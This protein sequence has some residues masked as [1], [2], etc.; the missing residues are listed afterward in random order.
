MY[1][2]LFGLSLPPPLTTPEAGSINDNVEDAEVAR[3][4]LE[5]KLAQIISQTN[6][7][8]QEYQAEQIVYKQAR[9]WSMHL[10]NMA[11]VHAFF[12]FQFCF[13]FFIVIGH[14]FL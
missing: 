9:S 6:K 11:A 7:E 10:A 4:A 14:T 5:N 13:N 3:R 8:E 12:E 2:L 1:C